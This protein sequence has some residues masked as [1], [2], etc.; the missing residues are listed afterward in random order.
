MRTTLVAVLMLGVAGCGAREPELRPRAPVENTITITGADGTVAG[1]IRL[2]REDY[3][4]ENMVNATPA[5]VLD[6][7]P[8]AF[9][10]VGLP[11]P[12]I[13]PHQRL[14]VV[15]PHIV[16]RRLGGVRMST[17]FDCGRGPAGLYADLY[18]IHLS[19]ATQVEPA[20]ESGSVVLT[21]VSAI[22]QNTGGTSGNTGCSSL[23]QLEARIVKALRE[24]L[25]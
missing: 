8:A 18:R 10:A 25:G 17:Y 2:T 9:A 19:V 3:V 21:R 4:A 23:G 22:G 1:E 12:E 15:Q 7:L 14:A 6:V 5:E 20:G 24:A 11:T 16:T 13:D